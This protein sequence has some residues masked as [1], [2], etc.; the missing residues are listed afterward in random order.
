M[1]GTLAAWLLLGCA[2]PQSTDS[3]P[4]PDP[5]PPSGALPSVVVDGEVGDWTHAARAWE[6]TASASA[7]PAGGGPPRPLAMSLQADG[8]FLY[9]LIELDRPVNLQSMVGSLRLAMDHDGNP[10]TGESA[11]GLD[12]ADLLVDFSH[13]PDPGLED[14]FGQGILVREAGSGVWGDAYGVDLLYAP[15][16]ASERFEV[17]VALP[18]PTPSGQVRVRLGAL[19]PTGTEVAATPVLEQA[20]GTPTSGRY[21]AKLDD[22]RRAGGTELRVMV[23]NVGDRGMLRTPEPYLR[24][25]AAMSPDVLL[26]DELNPS[27][28]APWLEET[29]GGLP[30]GEAWKVVVGEGGGRQRTAVASRLPLTLHPELARIP[31]PDSVGRLSGLPMSNQM[32]ADLATALQDDLPTVGATIEVAGRTIL[33]VPLDLM[34]CGRAEGPEDRA[35][36]M[37]VEAIRSAVGAVLAGGGIEG[38]VIGGDLNLVGSREPQDRLVMGLDPSGEPLRVAP[39]PRLDGASSTTWRSPGPFPPGR[40]DHVMVSGS[41]LEILRSFALDPVDLPQ[42]VLDALGLRRDDGEV[43]DHLPIVVDLRT[44]RQ[45]RV[46]G[47]LEDHPRGSAIDVGTPTR[48]DAQ[49]TGSVPN[50]LNPEPP[51]DPASTT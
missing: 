13:R 8:S 39:T 28:D 5:G 24:L 6:A 7:R 51:S 50:W 18:T 22:V 45:D 49:R 19:D 30:G 10:G 42:D 35:R 23:W 1:L 14:P 32:R 17:R 40:L 31:W 46:H 25:I 43:T 27:M 12:G 38:V 44:V 41:S 36:I 4:Q 15:T 3:S 26:L 9:L 16:W 48:R 37:A 29:L 21:R 34:C 11:G 20:P 2:G 47:P 33:L